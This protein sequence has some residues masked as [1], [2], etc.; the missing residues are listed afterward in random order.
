MLTKAGSKRGNCSSSTYCH[1]KLGKMAM[2]HGD[3]FWSETAEK[4]QDYQDGPRRLALRS[5]STTWEVLVEFAGGK[6]GADTKG[7]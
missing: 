1:E 2:I 6:V 3:D 7:G 5:R 4:K